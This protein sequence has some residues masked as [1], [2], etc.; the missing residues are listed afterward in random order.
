MPDLAELQ[1]D[2]G[3]VDAGTAST[4][5]TLTSSD[6]D[7]GATAAWSGSAAGTYGSF[8]IDASGHWS[9]AV[10]ATAGSAADQ[11]A[12]G[13]TRVETFT[14]TVTDDK[15]A[16]A[17]QVVTVTVTGT[18]DSPVVTSGPAAATGAVREAGNFDAG[19]IDAGIAAS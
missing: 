15:G 8:A 11:L 2:G 16:T 12:E 18:N 9:Y 17:T 13:D 14:A 4:G 3:A 1:P 7:T 5:G 6:V 19:A 10:D